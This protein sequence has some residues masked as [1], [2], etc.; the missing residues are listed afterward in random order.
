MRAR[1]VLRALRTTRQLARDPDVWLLAVSAVAL[2]LA[3]T[4]T[5]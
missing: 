3:L 2:M 1:R 4:G 5:I